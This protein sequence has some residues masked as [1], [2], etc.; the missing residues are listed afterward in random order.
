MNCE[1]GKSPII[2]GLS[3]GLLEIGKIKIGKKGEQ[4]QGGQSGSW[5]LPQRV[6]HFIVTTLERGQD[7]NFL[8]DDRL[9]KK[10]GIPE[11]PKELPITLLFDDIAA[12][13]QCRF[14]CYKGKVLFCSGDGEYAH[15]LTD[16]SG[17]RKEVTCPC[18][19]YTDQLFKG[20]D[21]KG[22]GKCKM[23]GKLSCMITG[24]DV[25]GGVW[26]FRTT[27]YNS[28]TGILSSLAFVKTMTGGMLAGIPLALTI[29]PKVAT[30]PEGQST[31]IQVVGIRYAGS[32]EDL[33]QGALKLAQ[34]NADFRAR[35]GSVEAE[36]VKL[37][38]VDRD[39]TDQAGDII[40]E[41]YYPPEA[42][43]VAPVAQ[44]VESQEKPETVETS[45]EQPKKR[46]RKQVAQ[47]S[48]PVEEVPPPVD[49]PPP[50]QLAAP[51]G[52][53]NFSVFD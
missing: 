38:S 53:S 2:K 20:D 9:Y 30:T 14:A 36:A 8:R 11:K 22:N 48:E 39:L 23:N 31:T 29:Q 28:N 44:E 41:E 50:A 5:Q 3:P 37:I 19:R 18:H 6:D 10:L 13:F 32:I 33:Q 43:L 49:E 26:V 24:A 27:S 15:Q 25:I 35:L 47:E 51:Q 16:K 46:S 21:G 4:R 12:N 52:A 1:R 34:R 42:E 40:A 7:N 45:P 17:E